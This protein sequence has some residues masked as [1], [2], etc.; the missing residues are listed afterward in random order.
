MQRCSE[1][2]TTALVRCRPAVQHDGDHRIAVSADQ[3]ALLRRMA[4]ITVIIIALIVDSPVSISWRS[5]QFFARCRAYREPAVR[6][7]PGPV[8]VCSCEV[9]PLTRPHPALY[10]SAARAERRLSGHPPAP[11]PRACRPRPMLP[12][13]V[14]LVA[15]RDRGRRRRPLPSAG[16]GRPPPPA[17]AAP[18]PPRYPPRATPSAC[19]RR[20]RRRTSSRRRPP[21]G[22]GPAWLG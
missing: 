14:P 5:L 4:T 21:A 11:A 20:A 22:A 6:A 18:A 16:A 10:A 15:R 7:H 17:V 2:K 19:L 8:R 1:S 9:C 13:P 3:V 12:P